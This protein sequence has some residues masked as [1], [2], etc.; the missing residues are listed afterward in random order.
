MYMKMI[1]LSII[2]LV[3][4]SACRQPE[5]QGDISST[6]LRIIDIDKLDQKNPIQE[7]MSNIKVLPLETNSDNLVGEIKRMEVSEFYLFILDHNKNFFTFTTD[8]Q[9]VCKMTATGK[10][11]EDIMNKNEHIEFVLIC[12]I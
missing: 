11:A 2:I 6:G 5:K 4:V 7:C 12:L 10:G 8:G 3:F 9:F 1:Y